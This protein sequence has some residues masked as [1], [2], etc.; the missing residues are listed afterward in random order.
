LSEEVEERWLTYA[1]LG[2]A[3]GCTAN[4]ARMHAVRRGW[5]RRAP[6]MVGGPARVLVPDGALAQR[7]RATHRAAPFVAQANGSERVNVQAIEALCEQLAIAN[8]R[9]DELLEEQRRL[10][11]AHEAERRQL[12]AA[13]GE[14]RRE[15][16]AKL[17][18]RHPWWRRWFR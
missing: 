13:H 17:T 14:E 11:A 8:R 5:S 15:W 1:E 2:V 7:P 9:I 18:D 6:N 3:L 16:L 4:A 10:K 12:R